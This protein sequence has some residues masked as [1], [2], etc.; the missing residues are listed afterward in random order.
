MLLSQ[1]KK[2]SF[3]NHKNL[4]EYFN[5]STVPSSK[6]Y[7]KNNNLTNITNTSTILEHDSLHISK[8]TQLIQDIDDIR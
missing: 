4:S 2:K 5:Y 7:H 1:K 3:R 8:P 6:S